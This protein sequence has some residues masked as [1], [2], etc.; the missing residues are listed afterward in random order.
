MRKYDQASLCGIA[1]T[2]LKHMQRAVGCKAGYAFSLPF[3]PFESRFASH[4]SKHETNSATGVLPVL[5]P[6]ASMESSYSGL[7]RR[8]T[9]HLRSEQNFHRG[10]PRKEGEWY[11]M[12]D[13]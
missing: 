8:R 2:C 1:R 6:V 13:E 5:Q 10:E 12:F 9:Q 3:G 4:V 11:L 7:R